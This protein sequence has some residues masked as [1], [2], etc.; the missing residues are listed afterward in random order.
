[1][2][3]KAVKKKPE[4]S[5]KDLTNGLNEYAV[6]YMSSMSSDCELV[7]AHGYVLSPDNILIFFMRYGDEMIECAR[8]QNWDSVKLVS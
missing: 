8:F 3:S 2:I 6:R 4:V 1:M 5:K 7:K